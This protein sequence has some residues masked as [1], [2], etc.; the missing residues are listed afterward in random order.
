[1]KKALLFTMEKNPDGEAALA[2]FQARGVAVDIRDVGKDPE[3]SRELFARTGRLG[4]PTI[5][6]DERAFQGFGAHR[7]EIAALLRD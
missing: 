1:M 4:V 2:F 7:E 6:I 5:V 3:A